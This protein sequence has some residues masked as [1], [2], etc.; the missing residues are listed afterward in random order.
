MYKLAVIGDRESVLGFMTVGFTVC[1]A[2]DAPQAAQALKK[3]ASGGEYAVICITETLAMQLEEE[4]G[5]Y[6]DSPLPAV[7]VIPG[8]QGSE[9][10]G[11]ANIRKSVQR[12]VG[13]DILFK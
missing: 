8:K 4:I 7:I 12:A 6:K 3:L 9:G 2:E 11:M 1:E 5:K 13:A 10:Y